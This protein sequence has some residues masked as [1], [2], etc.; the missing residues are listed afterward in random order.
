MVFIEDEDFERLLL[1][2]SL[3]EKERDRAEGLLLRSVERSA[4]KSQLTEGQLADLCDIKTRLL[5]SSERNLEGD[6]A[7]GAP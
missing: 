1:K 5:Y 7:T 2:I 3:L 6:A 4:R